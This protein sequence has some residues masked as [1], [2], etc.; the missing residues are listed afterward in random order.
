MSD[1]GAFLTTDSGVP[2]WTEGTL[3][4]SFI[5]KMTV[6]ARAF[7]NTGIKSSTPCL[8]FGV[9]NA[10]NGNNAPYME[11]K[12]KDGYWC[13]E[14]ATTVQ[15]P[16]VTCE[17][18]IFAVEYP[19]KLPEWGIAIWDDKGK[20]VLTSDTKPLS[21]AGEVSREQ[22]GTS[23]PGKKAILCQ[24]SG[25]IVWRL[26]KL[27]G[28]Y[29]TAVSETSFSAYFSGGRTHTAAGA[30]SKEVGGQVD[31]IGYTIATAPYIDCF[32]YD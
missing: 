26:Y 27:P 14:T 32:T 25:Y 24:H 23:Q 8:I 9:S 30:L 7:T 22:G 29:V 15:T 31:Y 12:V 4:L 13:V 19:Q 3:P 10:S 6:S 21:L 17:L 28:E 11:Q 16:D 20:R 18:Y 2:W 5:K 1:F